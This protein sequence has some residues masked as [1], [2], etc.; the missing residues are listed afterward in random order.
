MIEDKHRLVITISQH[1]PTP[2]DFCT[3]QGARIIDPYTLHVLQAAMVVADI[4]VDRRLA[5]ICCFSFVVFT[6]RWSGK[7][8]PVNSSIEARNKSVGPQIGLN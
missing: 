3:D 1:E 7:R 2:S 8:E 6:R 5:G 4:A